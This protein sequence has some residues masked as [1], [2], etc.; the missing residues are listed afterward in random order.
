VADY[1]DGLTFVIGIYALCDV[2]VALLRDRALQQLASRLRWIIRETD[3][4]FRWGGEEFVI[5][6][7]HTGPTEAPALGE[8]IRS[9]VAGRPFQAAD[10]QTPVSATVS[11]GVAGTS[12][13]PVD[14]DALIARADAACYRAKER[15]RDRVEAEPTAEPVGSSAGQVVSGA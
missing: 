5:L 8:R 14:P 11:V 2:P 9:A 12:S 7:A 4:L 1:A 13:W 10:G 3:L 6:L 15:G